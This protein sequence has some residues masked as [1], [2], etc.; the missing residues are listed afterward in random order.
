ML[1]IFSLVAAVCIFGG[2]A[3]ADTVAVV[4]FDNLP[5]GPSYFS[6]A[7]PAQTITPVAGVATFSGGVILGNASS[8]PAIVY[9][10]APNTYATASFGDSLP[11]TLTISIDPSFTAN[12]VSF[13]LFNGLTS[14]QSYFVNA[15]NGATLVASQ[16]FPSIPANS[17]SGY[18]LADL[19]AS[20]ITSVTITPTDIS[21]GWD[22]LLD[23]VAFNESIDQAVNPTVPEPSSLVLL[24]SGLAA[25]AGEI[26]RRACRKA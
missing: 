9:A 12:E 25:A 8:F 10:T 16:N 20:S 6:A 1:K 22:F 7:G 24:G 23:T 15:Y 17:A 13:A 14:P 21:G 18:A 4:T 5:A 3:H 11:S 2:V 19:L 26:Y